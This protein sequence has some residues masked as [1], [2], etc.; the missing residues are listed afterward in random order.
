[1]L[2]HQTDCPSLSGL[3]SCPE[4][5]DEE[6]QRF[7]RQY[8]MPRAPTSAPDIRILISDDDPFRVNRFVDTRADDP[9]GYHLNTAR[10]HKEEK[11][12]ARGW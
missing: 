3:D 12:I 7:P 11:G 9:R 8:G 6:L 1:M 4:A 2:D 5:L 10:G